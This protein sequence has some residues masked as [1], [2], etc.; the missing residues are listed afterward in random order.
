MWSVCLKQHQEL[1]EIGSKTIR[2]LVVHGD[3]FNIPG[4][5]GYA[6]Q[7]STRGMNR[8]LDTTGYKQIGK[9]IKATLITGEDNQQA[10]TEI[11]GRGGEKSPNQDETHA[12][13]DAH[14]IGT[15]PW[16]KNLKNVLGS[17]G[18]PDTSTHL[19]RFSG[20]CEPPGKGQGIKVNTRVRSMSWLC[21]PPDNNTTLRQS[22]ECVLY[23]GWE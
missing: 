9:P 7:V 23:W 16:M 5:A 12:V 17:E 11:T 1:R 21:T 3:M 13:R 15:K 8:T 2:S 14:M 20:R 19:R 18:F 10:S 6:F 22:P 4:V